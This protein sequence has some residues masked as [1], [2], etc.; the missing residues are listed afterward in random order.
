MSFA[1]GLGANIFL[2]DVP[3]RGRQKRDDLLLFSESN[4]RFIVEVQRSCQKAFERA[5]KRSCIG[6]IGCVIASKELKVFG[7]DGDAC[8]SESMA[9]L[10]EAWQKTLRSI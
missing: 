9:N 3:Y 10:K 4:S 1:G 6:L 7:L 8:I 2:S 5:M